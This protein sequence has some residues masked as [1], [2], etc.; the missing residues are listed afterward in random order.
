MNIE[1]YPLL[2]P[3]SKHPTK[4]KMPQQQHLLLIAHLL[5]L[6]PI[7]R[8]LYPLEPLRPRIPR[9]RAAA[10]ALA[11]LLARQPPHRVAVV[12]RPWRH[13]D[14][15]R[16]RRAPEPDPQRVVNVLSHVADHEGEEL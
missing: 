16:Q 1:Q 7:N 14:D 11:H 2:S 13:T 12:K 4:V 15:K 5:N 8:N 6:L 3:L 9:R 10:A